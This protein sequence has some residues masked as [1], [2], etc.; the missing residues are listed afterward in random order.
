VV[1]PRVGPKSVELQTASRTSLRVRSSS[2]PLG[3]VDLRVVFWG[4]CELLT[5]GQTC[6]APG[7]CSAQRLCWE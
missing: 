4:F 7:L 3:A 5:Q 1:E 2:V 6:E